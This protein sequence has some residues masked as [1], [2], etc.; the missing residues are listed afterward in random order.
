[1]MVLVLIMMAPPAC[2][3][4]SRHHMVL[5]KT[6]DGLAIRGHNELLVR[7]HNVVPLSTPKVVLHQHQ[8]PDQHCNLIK[9][10]KAFVKAE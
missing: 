9:C 2:D 5:D 10:A 3:L 1:M 7:M 4:H 6:P 8:Q